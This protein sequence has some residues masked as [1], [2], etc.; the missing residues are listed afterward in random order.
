[1]I[2]EIIFG[3]L[4]ITF[5][6]AWSLFGAYGVVQMRA[7]WRKPR[8]ELREKFPRDETVARCPDC[9][10]VSVILGTR[11]QLCTNIAEAVRLDAQLNHPVVPY[12]EVDHDDHDHEDLIGRL[13]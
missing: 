1:M 9:G 11:C 5:C 10:C 6:V 4:A 2:A 8:T 7:Q 12:A 13:R 3:A